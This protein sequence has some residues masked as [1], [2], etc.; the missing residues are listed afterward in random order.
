VEVDKLDSKL[1]D[2]ALMERQTMLTGIGYEKEAVRRPQI[3]VASS[4][5]EINPAAIHLDKVVQAVKNG[6]WA[7]G[8]T[9]REFVI[10]SICTSMAGDDDYHLPHRDLVAGYLETVA[11]TNLFDGMVFVPQCDDVIPGHLMAAA[12]LD[13]PSIFV[14]G[15]YMT[16]ERC[17]GRLIDP[18]DVASKH[19][20]KY[21]DGG[22]T[23][24]QFTL[25]TDRSCAGQGACPVFGTANTMS[26]MAEALGMSLPGN[27]S[28]PGAG[29]RLTR[30]A[31][32]TGVALMDLL[33]NKITA[34][35]IL[36]LDA[37]RNAVA[38][39][40]AVGGSNNGVLHLQSIASEVDIDITPEVFNEISKKVPLITDVSPSG[41]KKYYIQDLDEAGGLPAV[42]K[43]L[44][45]LLQLDVMTV[46][47]ETLKENLAGVPDGA[48]KIIKKLSEPLSE[49]GGLLFLTGNLA[50]TGALIKKSG[51]PESMYTFAGPAKIFP[52]EED[53]IKALQADQIADGTVVV[54]RNMGPKS[55]LGM[56]LLQ[57]FLWQLWSF[58]KQEKLAIITDGR[59]SGTNKGCA[60]GHVTPE[61]C[62]GGPLAFVE[63][64][65]LITIDIPNCRLHVNVSEEEFAR[66]RENWSPPPKFSKGKGYLNVYTKL[67][68]SANKGASWNYNVE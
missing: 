57:R 31:F 17:E 60:V 4:W 49:D 43:E 56:M 67:A 27:M 32:E 35:Q 3:G 12:R 28:T 62:E 42:M 66:R 39:L 51:V 6:I 54:V 41:S 50:P 8:G 58:N 1:P 11:K 19:L 52:W 38:V 59:Y 18:L 44:E 47:G 15:G 64:G 33:Q 20:N 29:S 14:T 48:R 9:P 13:L 22:Y 63:D 30:L 10:S 46:T 5:G 37:F 26:A 7:A 23:K 53:A 55:G 34:S 24:E 65:D 25:I 68:Q 45:P 21:K 2:F 61:A 40:M 16:L 36:T